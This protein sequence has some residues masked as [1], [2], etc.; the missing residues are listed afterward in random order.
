MKIATSSRPRASAAA[1]ISSCVPESHGF[2]ANTCSPYSRTRSYSRPPGPLHPGLRLAGGDEREKPAPHVVLVLRLLIPAEFLAVDEIGRV[3]LAARQKQLNRVVVV[4]R[5]DSPTGVLEPLRGNAAMF[6]AWGSKR[7]G[8]AMRGNLM[9]ADSRVLGNPTFVRNPLVHRLYRAA[10]AA[11]R[12]SGA[13]K[14]IRSCHCG[15]GDPKKKRGN[16]A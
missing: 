6:G 13:M 11:S 12:A 10:R 1:A 15:R 9:A 2:L 14:I 3:E 5:G 4:A 16:V 7:L 8:S